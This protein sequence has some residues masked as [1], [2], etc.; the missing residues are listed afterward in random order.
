MKHIQETIVVEG[1][2]DRSA[3][4]RAV[5]ANI[6]CT[7]G[8]GLNDNTISLIGSAYNRTGIIIFTDPDHA[9]REI[10]ERL[11]GLFPK[12]K[13]AF[14]TRAQSLKNGDIGIEN[15]DPGDILKALETAK[16]SEGNAAL[17]I[18]MND[19]YSLGLAGSKDSSE[20]REKAGAKLGIGYANTKTFLKRL[21]F[22]GISKDRLE[23]ALKE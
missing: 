23:E 17:E 19:L 4:L 10:R 2:D 11:T 1:K 15:A 16:A 12:A 18:S 8:Y 3:V 14:L 5:E 7:S 22:M 21:H 13:Q 9:G 20:K 6:I